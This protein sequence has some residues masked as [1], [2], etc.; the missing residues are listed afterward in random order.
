MCWAKI[1]ACFGKS[2]A[3][4]EASGDRAAEVSGVDVAAWTFAS[5]LTY[6]MDGEDVVVLKRAREFALLGE[7]DRAK[8]AVAA[9]AAVTGALDAALYGGGEHA[10]LELA[11]AEIDGIYKGAV[12]LYDV[13]VRGSVVAPY[14]R[15]TVKP[16]FD[17]LRSHGMLAI[18]CSNC[19]FETMDA[20]FN[21]F[22]DYFAGAGLIYICNQHRALLMMQDNSLPADKYDEEREKYLDKAF[23]FSRHLQ[24][25][26][27][28]RLQSFV[29]IDADGDAK[30]YT[31]AMANK[32][33]PGVVL[34]ERGGALRQFDRF[35]MKVSYPE[36]AESA[37]PAKE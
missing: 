22:V 18:H 10:V 3:A 20:V 7:E 6:V 30:T 8:V 23:F 25:D 5:P 2:K 24:N 31:T 33:K 12:R 17:W 37:E 26:C 27:A 35:P 32:G 15:A 19:A 36:P 14:L 11:A 4:E 29:C 1:K 9:G 28:K 34:V 16:F 21:D 13:K